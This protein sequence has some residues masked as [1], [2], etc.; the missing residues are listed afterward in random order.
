[1]TK[2]IVHKHVNIYEI[3]TNIEVVLPTFL[4]KSK[5]QEFSTSNKVIAINIPSSVFI[6]E[7]L[8]KKFHHFVSKGTNQ[9]QP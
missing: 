7:T 2:Y 9:R 6:S 1:M 5:S 4:Q 8:M 3:S